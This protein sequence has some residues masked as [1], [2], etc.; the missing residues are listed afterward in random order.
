M[1]IVTATFIISVEINKQFETEP[2]ARATPRLSIIFGD[3]TG[4]CS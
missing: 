2:K 1:C 3:V 4:Q